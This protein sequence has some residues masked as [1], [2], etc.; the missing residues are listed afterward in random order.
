MVDGYAKKEI[1]L[2]YWLLGRGYYKAVEAMEVGRKHHRGLRKDGAPEF[3]HQIAIAQFVRTLITDLQYPE[4]TMSTIF[5]HDIR[6]DYNVRDDEI[7]SMF[8]DRVANSVGYMT[9]E[10]SGHK[11]DPIEVFEQI[12]SDPIASVAKGADRIHNF[13]T[14]LE[15]FSEDK[16]KEY[17]REAEYHFIPMLKR[18]RRIFPQ[19]EPVYENIK[20]AL[21]AQMG[22]IKAIHAAKG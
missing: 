3:S 14:M 12:G 17:I 7:R 4:D 11:R 22:L 1:S 21:N 18:A 8:G 16:Q 6:E 5:L 15:A 19:Q 20:W 10:Y 9:K 13:S 2:R